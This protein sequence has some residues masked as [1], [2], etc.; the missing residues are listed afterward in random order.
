MRQTNHSKAFK[1]AGMTSWW[2]PIFLGFD[3]LIKKAMK[4]SS[5]GFFIPKD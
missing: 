4:I 3:N 5:L 2:K 1:R